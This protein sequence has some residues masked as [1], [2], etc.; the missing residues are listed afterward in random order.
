MLNFKKPRGGD[1]EVTLHFQ[2]FYHIEFHSD[3]WLNSKAMFVYEIFKDVQSFFSL[4]FMRD[5]IFLQ[6]FYDIQFPLL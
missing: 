4:F 5:E 3:N 1:N 2:K 6:Q